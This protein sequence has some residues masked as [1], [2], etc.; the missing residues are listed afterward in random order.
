M[1]LLL[2]PDKSDRRRLL[3]SCT[4][5]RG[6]CRA[7]A[8]H[9]DL[10]A[11]SQHAYLCVLVLSCSHINSQGWFQSKVYNLPSTL[12]VSWKCTCSSHFFKYA[13]DVICVD[14]GSKA[15]FCESDSWS[16][17]W[18]AASYHCCCAEV[19]CIVVCLA[20]WRNGLGL[21]AWLVPGTKSFPDHF[22]AMR[23]LLYL[24]CLEAFEGGGFIVYLYLIIIA[25]QTTIIFLNV[26]HILSVFYSNSI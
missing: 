4:F 17:L 25:I 11:V 20:V 14:S 7:R 8:S 13:S 22:G 24:L 16:V 12:K 10:M 19:K 15:R 5:V 21:F 23:Q 1:T 9:H 18:S 6:Y 26:E 3:R 2:K